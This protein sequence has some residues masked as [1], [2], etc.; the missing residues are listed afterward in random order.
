MHN[1]IAETLNSS[2]FSME[3]KTIIS[4]FILLDLIIN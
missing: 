1:F 3:Q 4:N 2:D